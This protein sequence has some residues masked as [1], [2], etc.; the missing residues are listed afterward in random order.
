[1]TISLDFYIKAH[2][3]TAPN[4]FVV[5]QTITRLV[6]H[7]GV[8]GEPIFEVLAEIQSVQ[9]INISA[10]WHWFGWNGKDLNQTMRSQDNKDD[11]DDDDDDD[12]DDDDDDDDDVDDDDDDESPSI[13][14][15]L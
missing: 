7:F 13:F 8:L 11:A 14:F 10:L 9:N 4:E 2:R 6:W 12:N 15:I 3:I 5:C 1:M